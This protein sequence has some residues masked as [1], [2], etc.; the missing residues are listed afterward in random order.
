MC[1]ACSG[2]AHAA[3]DCPTANK[4]ALLRDGV[5]EQRQLVDQLIRAAKGEMPVVPACLLSTLKA[6]GK[7]CRK[8]EVKAAMKN[9]EI[10]P[11]AS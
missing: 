3:K 8:R 7:Y 5:R 9:A 4:I 6:R 1:W 10:K 11:I 2:Y